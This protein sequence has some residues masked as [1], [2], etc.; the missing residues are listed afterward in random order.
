LDKNKEQKIKQLLFQNL[1]LAKIS[2]A[3]AAIITYLVATAESDEKLDDYIST[4]SEEYPFLNELEEKKKV[5]AKEELE[6][7]VH[8][9]VTDLIK[10]DPAL[11]SEISEY[12]AKPEITAEDILIKYPQFKDYLK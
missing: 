8:K 6:D 10:D 9:F 5:I 7:L 1:S 4:L 2:V 12:A 3:D 11:A